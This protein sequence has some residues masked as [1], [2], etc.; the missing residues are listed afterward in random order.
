M[1]R[2]THIKK[3]GEYKV[4]NTAKMKIGQIWIDCI[5]YQSMKDGMVWVREKTDFNE[6]FEKII[7]NGGLPQNIFSVCILVLGEDGKVLAVSRKDDH[8]KFGLPGGKIEPNETPALAIERELFEETG[9]ELTS[10]RFQFVQDCI[11]KS[12]MKPCAVFTGCVKGEIN[13]NE[14]HVV[15]YVDPIVL[16]N[17]PFGEFNKLTFELLNFRY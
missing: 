13:H 8:E 6:N 11:D 17:G 1:E 12:G 2:Y 15:K 10:L 4:L 9:L 3:G 16:I 14:P 5:N 7:D